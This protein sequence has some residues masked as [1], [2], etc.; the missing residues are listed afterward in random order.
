MRAWETVGLRIWGLGGNEECLVVRETV[1]TG[2]GSTWRMI[3][4]RSRETDS[5]SFLSTNGVNHSPSLTIFV[6]TLKGASAATVWI[7]DVQWFLPRSPEP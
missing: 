3:R 2:K 5:C 4:A 7:H 1:D 6:L